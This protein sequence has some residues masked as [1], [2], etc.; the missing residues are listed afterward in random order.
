MLKNYYIELVVGGETLKWNPG[1]SEHPYIKAGSEVEIYLK[2][3]W[4]ENG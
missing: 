2:G 4:I 3:T 1:S